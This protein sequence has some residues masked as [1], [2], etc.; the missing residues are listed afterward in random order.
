MVLSQNIYNK[1]SFLFI[2]A[3]NSY[4]ITVSICSEV[5]L[6]KK[7]LSLLVMN[8]CV[9]CLLGTGLKGSHFYAMEGKL[10]CESCYMVRNNSSV[11]CKY[12][13]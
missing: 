6:W 1:E 4:D 3:I 2:W 9:F 5:N 10:Y 12:W 7:L 8:I 11:S 13:I